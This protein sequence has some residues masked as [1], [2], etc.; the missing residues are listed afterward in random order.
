MVLQGCSSTP[1]SSQRCCHA[2]WRRCALRQAFPCGLAQWG[3]GQA[4]MGALSW[5]PLQG[6]RGWARACKA[7]THREM[8]LTHTSVLFVQVAKPLVQWHQGKQL[9]WLLAISPGGMPSS[10]TASVVG[11]TT[12]LGLLEGTSS[13]MFALALVVTLI[14]AY[15]ATGVRLH[16][17]AHRWCLLR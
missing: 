5:Y 12:A 17:G 7:T 3:H 8:S 15:D 10:H 16:A 6:G 11:L 14:V 13:T 4:A 2:S 1:A 9:D